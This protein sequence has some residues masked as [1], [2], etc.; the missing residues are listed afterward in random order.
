MVF[1][2]AWGLIT[3]IKAILPSALEPTVINLWY[4]LRPV[5]KVIFF[6]HKRYC[7]VCDSWSCLFLSYG[8]STRNR[9]GVVCPICFSHE[10]HRLAW[11]FI[12]TSTDLRF[13][14]PKKLLHFAPEPEFE[15]NLKKL[16]WIEYLSTDLLNTRVV[17]RM[18]ITNIKRPDDSFDII[19]CSHVL[20]HVP[21]DRKAMSELFRV[22]KPGGW[23]LLQVPI[24]GDVSVEDLS[25]KDP[26]ER[27][28]LFGQIDHVRRYGLDIRDRLTAAGFNV[29]LIYGEDVVE[30]WCEKRPCVYGGSPIFYCRKAVS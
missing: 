24:S 6:G 20:E 10:R 22:L 16:P 13:T 11:V 12:N 15:R 23:A 1:L 4:K 27:E 26:A 14:I 7:P 3:K 30:P 29:D 9:K 25:I 17:E 2:R 5:I 28:R 18:D 19:L 8:P 21:E